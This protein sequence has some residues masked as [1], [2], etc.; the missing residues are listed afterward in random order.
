MSKLPQE[1]IEVLEKESNHEAEPWLFE[2]VSLCG[3][4]VNNLTLRHVLI[5][6]GISNPVL[7]GESVDVDTLA[8]FLWVISSGFELGN[9]KA[10]DKF[11]EKIST[12]NYIKLLEEVRDY[13]EGALSHSKAMT[14]DSKKQKKPNAHFVAYVV[15]SF[16]S[17]YSW[18]IE[19]IMSLPLAI[20]HQLI[21]VINER[22]CA[23]NDEPYSITRESDKLINRHIRKTVEG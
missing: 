12:I 13:I 22:V 20:I 1:I 19:Y 10:R 16:A 3:I 6:D 17:A 18:N 23:T 8:V 4:E 2:S 15:D 5:L 9:N 11:I 21:A 7:T 14:D